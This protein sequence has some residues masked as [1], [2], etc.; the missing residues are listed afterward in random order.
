MLKS[1]YTPHLILQFVYSVIFTLQHN[2]FCENYQFR[3]LHK[4]SVP[5]F[6]ILQREK[7]LLRAV[8]YHRSLLVDAQETCVVKENELYNLEEQI[9]HAQKQVK[10]FPVLFKSA[11]KFI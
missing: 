4:W 11:F 10:R 7:E 3:Y 9:N 2:I 6:S 5:F 1:P 8:D